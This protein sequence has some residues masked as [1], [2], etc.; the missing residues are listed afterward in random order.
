MFVFNLSSYLILDVDKKV[1]KK[2]ELPLSA[3]ASIC[4]LTV[5]SLSN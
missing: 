3:I 1:S 4:F 2:A 5:G